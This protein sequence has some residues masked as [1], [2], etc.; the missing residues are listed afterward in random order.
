MNKFIAMLRDSYRE[1]G[2]ML[3]VML[4]FSLLLIFFIASIGFR[5]LSIDE[6]VGQSTRFLNRILPIS[7]DYPKFGSPV[8][9]IE[10][11]KAGNAAEPWKGTH[12]FEFVITCPDDK[13]LEKFKTE[14]RSR[15]LPASRAGVERFVKQGFEFLDEVTVKS[16]DAKPNVLRFAVHAEKTKIQE[17]REWPHVPSILFFFEAPLL[18]NSLRGGVY[19]ML[20]WLVN[21]AGSWILLAV[22]VVVTA[23]FIPNLL[24]KGTIDLVI[25]K[26]ISRPF[27]LVSKYLGGLTYIAILTAFTALGVWFVIGLRSGLWSP[28][29]LLIIPILIL[30]FAVLYAVS[31]LVAVLTRSTLVAILATIL[32]WAIF[33]GV[34]KVNDGVMNRE[35]REKKQQ[36]LTIPK[37]GDMESIDPDEV[38][39]RLDPDA[40]LWGVLPRSFFLVPKILH[41]PCPRTY[42]LD[43]RLGRVIA[44]GVLSEREFKKAGYEEEPRENWAEMICVS[45]FFIM[46]CLALSS[47]RMV[48]RD[49]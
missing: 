11:Y 9:S 30:Y 39:S 27:L 36:A 21:G 16:I 22:S 28:N 47:W 31:T 5:P 45:V 35:M 6:L 41:F 29:F 12:D 38:L 34:G 26:P 33:W 49:G 10:N 13:E 7:P 25:S 37:P 20:K 19:F 43:S 1:A 8:F 24:A 4:V 3:Q 40:P 32:A 48:T 17:V 2:W 23:G 14:G 42:E 46:F 18:T 44:S 15:Q